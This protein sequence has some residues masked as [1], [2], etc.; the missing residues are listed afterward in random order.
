MR[1]IVLIVRWP[2]RKAAANGK[3]SGKRVGKASDGSGFEVTGG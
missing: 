1:L 3:A 2:R